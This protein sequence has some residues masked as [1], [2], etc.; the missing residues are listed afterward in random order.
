MKKLIYTAL[1]L[2]LASSSWAQSPTHKTA[3]SDFPRVVFGELK[4]DGP[5]KRSDVILQKGITVSSGDGNQ[6]EVVSY[7]LIMVPKNG[8]P[9]LYSMNTAT[10]TETILT[11][12]YNLVDGDKI[13]VESVV[14]KVNNDASQTVKLAPILFIIGN[15]TS[16]VDYDPYEKEQSKKN[17]KDVKLP[18]GTEVPVANFGTID[19]TKTFTLEDLQAQTEILVIGGGAEYKVTQFKMIV[20]SK[21]SPA[22]M[23]SSSG[24]IITSDMHHILARMKSGDRI[25]IEGISATTEVNGEVFKVNLSP[26]VITVP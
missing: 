18:K 20:V 12:L 17:N 2:F 6:Y 19:M 24:S 10:F 3:S 21:E 13:I 1:C 15:A 7:K 23:A 26:V 5:Y 14:A 11:N 22:V 25:L 9:S 4:Q 8:S 16:D